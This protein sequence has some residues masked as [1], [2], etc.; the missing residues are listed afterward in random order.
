MVSPGHSLSRVAASGGGTPS[1]VMPQDLLALMASLPRIQ[2][3]YLSITPL[4]V[5]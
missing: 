1:T 4:S 2:A 5:Y 3:F